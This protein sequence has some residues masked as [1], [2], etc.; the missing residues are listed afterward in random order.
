MAPR[1]GKNRIMA[2]LNTKQARDLAPAELENKLKSFQEELSREFAK[3]STEGTPTKT[4]KI[5]QLKR[6]IAMIHTITNEKMQSGKPNKKTK[7][8]R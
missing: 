4:G 7:N 3:R 6:I 1:R 2:L 5:R 8:T